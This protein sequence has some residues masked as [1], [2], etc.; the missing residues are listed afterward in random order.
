M[1][2]S[3]MLL[4]AFRLFRPGGAV[5]ALCLA[6]VVVAGFPS[7]A[8]AGLLPFPLN[9]NQRGTVTCLEAPVTYDVYLPP[10]YSTNGVALPILYTFHPSGGGE[11]GQFQTVC[12]SLNMI[13]VG[14]TGSKNDVSWDVVFK[15]YFAV[16]RDLRQRVI[17]DPTAEFLAGFSGGGEACYMCSRARPQHVAGIF[18]MAGWLGRSLD[19]YSTDRVQTNLLVAR[20]TGSSDT[21]AIYYLIRDSNYLATCNVVLRD[22]SFSG[23]HVI[24]P[25]STKTECLTWLINNRVPAHPNDRANAQALANDW[26]Q[27][28]A[29]GDE[30]SV[31]QECV[32]VLM[33][34][35]RTWASLQAQLALD[36]LTADFDAS[37][38]YLSMENLAQ[39][40][41]AGDMF[42]Y[43]ARAAKLDN[44]TQRYRSFMKALTGVT[45]TLGDHDGDIRTLLLT[46]GFP[47][48]VL[49]INRNG[50]ASGN[51]LWIAKD[52]PGL[53]YSAQVRTNL[54]GAWQ[55]A[56][57]PVTESNTTWSASVSNAPGV[58]LEFFRVGA[59]PADALPS[60]PEPP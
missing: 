24:P 17:F 49:H 26:Q 16:A 36:S 47:S 8:R 23:D 55:D 20:A 60:P 10:G 4:P 58:D 12:A 14:I 34:Q 57:L 21:G 39:G 15:E 27:R 6:L 59:T 32:Y 3:T 29:S 33:A 45:A 42:Y 31:L 41:H 40:N 43:Q 18:P 19:Y 50:D 54:T 38:R 46:N 48:P 25:D 7:L 35:P 44:D 51:V 56:N 22:W 1:N 52:A 30:Q 2:S 37:F 5:S 53:S 13:V 9:A 28:I 11:V